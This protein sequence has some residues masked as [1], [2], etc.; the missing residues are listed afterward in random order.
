MDKNMIKSILNPVI[1]KILELPPPIL[2]PFPYIC[3]NTSTS[4][5]KNKALKRH[6][7][8][9]TNYTKILESTMASDAIIYFAK[10]E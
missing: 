4:G 3:I 1:A 2:L 5:R 8:S 7:K 6:L 10:A 9:G